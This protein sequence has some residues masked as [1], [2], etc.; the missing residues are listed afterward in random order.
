MTLKQLKQLESNLEKRGYKKWTTRL[1]NREDYAWV[2]SFGI[3]SDK[4]GDM[5]NDYQIFF[6]V[7]CWQDKRGY[8]NPSDQG[9]VWITV[10]MIPTE[11]NNRLDCDYSLQIDVPDIDLCEAMMK[12]FFETA[13]QY[14]P[15]QRTI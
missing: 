5:T 15:S 7:F 8:I 3:H 2:K 14:I 9:E 13:K 1:V 4:D 10:T 12:E 6:R 11:L